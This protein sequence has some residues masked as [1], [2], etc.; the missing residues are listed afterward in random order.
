MRSFK[1]FF[2]EKNVFGLEEDIIIDGVGT[3]SAKLD[4]G[5]GAYNVLHGED[6][7]FGKDKKTNEPIVRFTTVNAIQLEKKVEDTI[8]INLGGVNNFEERPVCLFD[9]MIGGRK[10]PNIPFSIG[11]RANNDHKVLIGKGFIKNQLDALIDVSLK[12]I[13]DEQISVEL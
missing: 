5:N 2:V 8:E 3:I 9:C 7:K 6:L 1:Q 4:T 13:A 10:F 11:N 12:N